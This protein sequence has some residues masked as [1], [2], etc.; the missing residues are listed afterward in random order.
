MA[1]ESGDDEKVRNVDKARLMAEAE[2]PSREIV[3][4]FKEYL[5]DPVRYR[6]LE[7][8]DPQTATRDKAGFASWSDTFMILYRMGLRPEDIVETGELMAEEKGSLFD[9]EQKLTTKSLT[10]LKM[11]H[12]VLLLKAKFYQNAYERARRALP[13]D[14]LEQVSDRGEPTTETLIRTMGSDDPVIY[15]KTELYDDL[16]KRLSFTKEK[17]QLVAKELEK[18]T[19]DML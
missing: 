15:L 13:P 17:I 9:Y 14:T 11:R 19:R 16:Y 8:A 7:Q 1:F 4:Q 5:K 10:M 6:A 12:G 2:D 3:S 18:R